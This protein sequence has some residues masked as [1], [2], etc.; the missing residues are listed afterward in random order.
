[1]KKIILDL[2]PNSSRLRYILHRAALEVWKKNSGEYPLFDNRFK[3][4]DYINNDILDNEV[5]EYLEFGVFEGESILY[6][7]SLNTAPES[8]FFGFDT[9]EGLPEDWVEFSRTVKSKTFS[10]DGGLPKIEDERVTFMKGLFQ[11]T[12]PGFLKSFK[13]TNQLVIH[14][15]SDLYSATLF[16]LTFMDDLLIP[17]TVIIFDEFYSV[18]DE[19]RALEDYASAYMRSYEVLAATKNHVQVAIRLL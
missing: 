8:T 3:M 14:N 16:V 15:D 7:A 1:L 17:G 13:S 6:F 9:F 5:I 19:F 11:E 2:L 4:Y 10:T 18:L 12:L